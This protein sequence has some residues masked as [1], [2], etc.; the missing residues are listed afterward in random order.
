MLFEYNSESSSWIRIDW[1][2]ISQTACMQVEKKLQTKLN[3]ICLQYFVYVIIFFQASGYNQVPCDFVNNFPFFNLYS[4]NFVKN[5]SI[6]F[7][8][9]QQF[10]NEIK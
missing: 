7:A 6:S 5:F 3:N 10:D 8:Y 4:F 2:S 9:Q 1:R